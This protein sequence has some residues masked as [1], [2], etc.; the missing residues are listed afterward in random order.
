MN[1]EDINLNDKN[2]WDALK[3]SIWNIE[4]I[5]NPSED[6]SIYC[7]KKAWNTL[8]FIHDPNDNIIKEA[9]KNNGWAIQF[10]KKPSLEQMLLAVENNW[11]SI[12]FI[13]DPTEEIQ[14][15]AINKSHSAIKFM[16]NPSFKSKLAAI[17]KN[18]EAIKNFDYTES[19]F[20]DFIKYNIN[21]LKYVSNYDKDKIIDAIQTVI[22]KDNITKAYIYDYIKLNNLQIDKDKFI[23]DNGSAV[24]K[25]YYV[26]LNLDL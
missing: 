26:D 10:V 2:K 21:V 20:I 7:V 9:L 18:P 14:L 25:E 1:I 17:I 6:M 13:D 15:A 16:K 8:K 23:Y 24:S 12:R 22:S 4:Y 5:D 3:K 19:E 11:E